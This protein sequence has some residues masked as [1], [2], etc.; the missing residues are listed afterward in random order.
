MTSPAGP[1]FQARSSARAAESHHPDGMP[2]LARVS[3]TDWV[4][5]GWNVGGCAAAAE[6]R[7]GLRP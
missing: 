4:D 3:A 2:L 7:Q 1:G 5:G 6:R